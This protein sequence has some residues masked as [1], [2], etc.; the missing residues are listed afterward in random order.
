[1]AH[2]AELDQNNQVLRVIVVRNEDILNEN[3][4]ED[5]KIGI[6]FC[7][8]LFGEDTNWVQTSYNNSFRNK[9][10]G[11]TDI[12]RQDL[13]AFIQKQP[14]PSWILNQQ[15]LKWESPIPYPNQ[16]KNYIWNEELYQSDNFQGWEE[17]LFD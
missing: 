12:Y 8:N 10:A 15:S 16:E 3:N 2:F 1:M 13:D 9:Y 6:E 7:K 4:Q 14:Y 17:I 11:Q 5:E